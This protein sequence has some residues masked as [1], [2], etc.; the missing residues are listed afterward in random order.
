M[1]IGESVVIAI[2]VIRTHKMRSF[3]TLLGI[4]IGVTAIIGMQSLI[5]GFQKNLESEMDQLGANVFYVNKYPAIQM[6]DDEEYRNRKDITIQEAIAIEQYCPSVINIG[7][8]DGQFGIT[9][10]VPLS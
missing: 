10:A 7:P 3:L 5:S 9:A 4:I 8:E 6:G 2:D 1:Q